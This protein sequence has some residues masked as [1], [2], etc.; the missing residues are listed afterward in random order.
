MAQNGRSSKKTY[1][2]VHHK[3]EEMFPQFW[4]IL[5]FFH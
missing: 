5:K 2:K 1:V 4:N 3:G